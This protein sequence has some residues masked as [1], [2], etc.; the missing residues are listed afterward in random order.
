VLL[1]GMMG[2]GKTT[3]GRALASRLGR[4][5][6]DSDVMVEARTGA[7]V[8]EIFAGR[9]EAAFR[10]EESAA[11]IAALASTTPAVIAV[12][13][14]AVLD[15]ANRRRIAGGRLVVWLRA[16]AEVL[17]ERVRGGTHRPLLAEDPG[18]T[19]RRL[20]AERAPLYAAL[21]DLVIDVDNASVANTVD[22]IVDALAGRP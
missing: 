17:T 1:V 21:A 22:T 13:G 6:L 14:G 12:A 18:A 11:L 19:L 16:E 7:T 20:C 15:P 4:S 10:T 8:A 5:L 3:V 2:S 9:G